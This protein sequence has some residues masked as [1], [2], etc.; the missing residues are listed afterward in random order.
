MNWTLS[1]LLF[2]LLSALWALQF[3]TAIYVVVV[4]LLPIIIMAFATITFIKKNQR[5][6]DVL[7]I[8]YIVAL[9]MLFYLVT[10]VEDL[11]GV[12]LSKS[13]NEEGEDLVWN[14][15]G[16][17]INLCFALFAGFILFF[18]QKRHLFIRLFYI[19]TAIIMIIAVLLTGSRKSLLILLMPVLIF[20]YIK[21]KKHFVIILLCLPIIGFLVYYLIMNVDIFYEV[22]G[23]RIEEMIAILSDD[24][25]GSEDDSR[26]ILIEFGLNNFLDNPLLG[27]GID[28]FRLLSEQIFP[29]KNFYAHNNYVEL[30][31]D[32]GIIGL[33]IYYRAYIY[34][35][36]KLRNHSDMLSIWGIAFLFIL[37]FLGFVEVLYYEPLEQLII[38]ILFCIVEFN[39]NKI[40]LLDG[41]RDKNC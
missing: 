4:H 26:I 18:H 28:N 41:E 38:C 19:I 29:G 25:T 12:R 7:F 6:N 33:F 11:V 21:Q 15:N 24:T 2:F 5:V 17:G 36:S 22:M 32:V 23:S 31:V 9:L 37:L 30:L 16:V 20:L 8:I 40:L 13:L 14:S 27:V 10:H 3:K 39:K 34:I 35:Y 1:Y